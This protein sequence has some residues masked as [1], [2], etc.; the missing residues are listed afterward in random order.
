VKRE[1]LNARPLAVPNKVEGMRTDSTR[2]RELLKE[3]PALHTHDVPKLCQGA[4][5]V[6][7]YARSIAEEIGMDLQSPPSTFRSAEPIGRGTITPEY[8]EALKE[9]GADPELV[10]WAEQRRKQP[11]VPSVCKKVAGD[12]GCGGKC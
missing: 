1:P 10:E 9:V 11:P 6:W 12:C 4:A 2:L 5:H 7:S 8:I 3:I